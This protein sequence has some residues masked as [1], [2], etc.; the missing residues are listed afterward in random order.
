MTKRNRRA[1]IRLHTNTSIEELMRL[2]K[3]PVDLG[4]G[5]SVYGRGTHMYIKTNATDGSMRALRFKSANKRAR[6]HAIGIAADLRTA[7][8][9]AA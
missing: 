1:Q 9:D 6:A 3:L 8:I 5:C 4:S 7:A 2:A